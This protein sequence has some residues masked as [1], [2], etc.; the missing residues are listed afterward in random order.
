M[1]FVLES[2]GVLIMTERDIFARLLRLT[3]PFETE[4]FGVVFPEFCVVRRRRADYVWSFLFRRN[5]DGV[6]EVS[7][8]EKALDPFCSPSAMVWES[9]PVVVTLEFVRR[10][11][12]AIERAFDR[13]RYEWLDFEEV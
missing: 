5:S 13:L 6:L 11:R 8:R 12:Y 3:R 2:E 9:A 7:R 4:G 1:A 10:Y